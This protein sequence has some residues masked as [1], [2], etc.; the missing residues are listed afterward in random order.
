MKETVKE[1]LMKET[2]FKRV[3]FM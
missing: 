3:M 2:R 1:N